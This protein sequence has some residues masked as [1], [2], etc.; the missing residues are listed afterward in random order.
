MV[1][2][3]RPR[4]HPH[5]WQPNDPLIS[6]F[7]SVCR[8]QPA[9]P[10]W[11]VRQI[12]GLI[13]LSIVMAC[14][15]PRVGPTRAEIIN[16]LNTNETN[17]IVE[18][19]AA[20]A[21]KTATIPA[22]GFSNKFKSAAMLGSDTIQP[23]D[24]LGLTIWE[25]VESSLLAAQNSNSTI[26]DEVQ[27]DGEGYIFIPYAGRIKAAGH[28]P[29]SIRQHLTE[30]LQVQTPDPQVQVR[31]SSGDGATVSVIGAVVKQGIYPIERPTRTLGAMLARAGGVTIE[32]EVAQ[33]T[34]LRGSLLE[35]VWFQDL[36][37][38]PNTDI[39]L[40][41]GDR[42]LVET[43][44]RAFTSL[45]STGTQ[46]RIGFPTQTISAIEALALVGGLSPVTSDP[47]GIFVFRNETAKTANH[48]LGRSDLTGEVKIIYILDLT[49][50]TGIFIARDFTIR[51][52]D[53]VHV[54]EAAFTQW[55]KLI[56]AITGSLDA[57][58]TINQSANTLSL[59]P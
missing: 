44:T 34:I 22:L 55:N 1:L 36:Y 58:N 16:D 4:T 47:K 48:V 57:V 59:K 14:E 13:C 28:S 25:S 12:A 39:P 11:L 5:W 35:K 8:F 21:Q 27:V 54:T 49:K 3:Y 51:D 6:H 40:R 52:Q 56:A 29:E 41:A 26:L 30:M 20:V 42:V 7:L 53:T 10:G 46:A 17:L 31:R 45:G 23:G 43:D 15:L 19:D 9:S 2:P 18:V 50:P 33:I 24:T 38:H 37:N 32:P